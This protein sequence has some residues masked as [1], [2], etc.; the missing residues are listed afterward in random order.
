MVTCTLVRHRAPLGTGSM[1]TAGQH[2]GAT[3]SGAVAVLVVLNAVMGTGFLTLPWA[4]AET[5][6]F[7]HPTEVTDTI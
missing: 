3:F 2:E 4:F 6:K 7:V 1:S 5:G